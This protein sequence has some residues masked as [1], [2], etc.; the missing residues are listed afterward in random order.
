MAD[1]L[2]IR[3]DLDSKGFERG[4][5][6]LGGIAARGA[7]GAVKAISGISA[8]LAAAGGLAIRTGAEF[9]AGMS[10]V[11]AISGATGDEMKRMSEQAKQLGAD[12]AFS[13]SEAAAGME[14]LASAGFDAAETMKAMPG[15]LDLA[16]VSG[17]DVAAAS[18]TAASTIRA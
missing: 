14:N 11:K 2:V 16:A 3:T 8:G 18:E 1:K 9:E 17:G 10:R 13:A 6:G 5:K 7:A 12:T 4:V 15:L